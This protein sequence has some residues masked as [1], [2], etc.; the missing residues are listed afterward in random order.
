MFLSQ[1]FGFPLSVSF[2]K[3]PI[4][5]SHSFTTVVIQQRVTVSLNNTQITIYVKSSTQQCWSW[6]KRPE[7]YQRLHYNRW[8]LSRT[9]P[10]IWLWHI[11]QYTLDHKEFPST[12]KSSWPFKVHTLNP[13]VNWLEGKDW[14]NIWYLLHSKCC[15]YKSE[16]IFCVQSSSPPSQARLQHPVLA[17]QELLWV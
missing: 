13:W 3:C 14:Y 8:S 17:R 15:N 11:Y 2:P 4:F 1:Y 6:S 10:Q 16:H 5:I 12:P 9:Q 7:S